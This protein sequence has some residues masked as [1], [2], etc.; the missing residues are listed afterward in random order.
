MS[1]KATQPGT[2]REQWSGQL[3]FLLSAIGSA[4]GLGNIWR[5][6]GV[7]YTSGGGA[8]IVPYVVALLTAGIPIL[9]LDYALGHRYRGSAPAVFRRLGKP[10]EVFGWLQVAICM[11]IASYYVVI[12]AW[13]ASYVGFSLNL[14]WGADPTTFFTQDFLGVSDP[15]FTT[16]IGWS[17]FWPV[18]VLWALVVFVLAAKVNK[19]LELTNRL[20]LPLLVVLFTILVVRALFLPGAAEGLNALFTPDWAALAQPSVWVAAYTQ[21][22]FSLSV[23]FGIMMTYSSYLRPRANLVPTGLVAAFANSSFEILAGIGVFATLGFMAVREGVGV[24]QLEGITGVSLSFMTFPQVISMM[25]G[26]PIFGV[27][28]FTSLLLAGFTSMVSIVEVIVAAVREKF[29]LSR[30]AAVA[31]IGGVGTLASVMLFATTNGLNALDTVDHFVNNVG[32]LSAAIFECIVV[33]LIVRKLPELQ[34]HLNQTS[35][36][37]VGSWWR[38]LVGI[39]NPIALVYVLI[40][41]VTSLL[42]TGY[43]DYPQAFVTAFGWGTVGFLFVV[44]VIATLLRWRT[45]VDKFTPLPLDA[46]TTRSGKEVSA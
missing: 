3:G 18:L 15:G 16:T 21:I 25:P 30:P 12:L 31:I 1:E 4:I 22:F 32:L 8:F 38:V 24:D 6:P 37:Q 44:A 29:A 19:G 35:T 39:V 28:F 11:V 7:A 10:F 26:G 40:A 23:A 33:A 13:A 9:L 46:Y 36:L 5:F 43:G 34:H 41:T 20:A 27:L 17:V 14:A 45:D 42:I 2:E